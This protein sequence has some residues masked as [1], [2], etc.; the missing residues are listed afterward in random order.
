[1]W[2]IF[3]IVMVTLYMY[4]HFQRPVEALA[5][6]FERV[7]LAATV[8]RVPVSALTQDREL[9]GLDRSF[10]TVAM[11]FSPFYEFQSRA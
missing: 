11:N 2:P 5:F 9:V 10:S 1:M 8:T 6:L 7:S 4:C 3:L